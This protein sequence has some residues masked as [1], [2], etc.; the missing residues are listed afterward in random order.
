MSFSRSSRVPELLRIGSRIAVLPVIHGSGQFSLTVRNWLLE[1]SFDCLAVPIPPSFRDA[2]EQAVVELP[3]PS[4]VLQ[5]PTPQYPA[6]GSRSS[7]GEASWDGSEPDEEEE[8]DTPPVS[9]VP[10]DPCQ[11]VIMAIRAAMGEHIPRQYIDLETD[12][13]QPYSAVM[14]DPFAVRQVS[15]ERF[16][17]ALLPSIARPPDDQTRS[18]I[19]HMAWRLA[20]L[21][22]KYEKI[23]LPASV[24]HWPWIREAY[25]D[26]FGPQRPAAR[27]L[28]QPMTVTSNH[29][30]VTKSNRHSGTR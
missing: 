7:W 10:V 25:T 14:P 21:E 22:D 23:L 15:P 13:F 12:P 11:P 20:E 17:A 5:P 2:V 8:A 26:L 30:A 28:G 3:R 18:R 19:L 29:L 1:E 6:P 4:I 27:R 24:L 16:A 9:Y